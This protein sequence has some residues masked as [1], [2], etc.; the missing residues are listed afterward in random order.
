MENPE[1]SGRGRKSSQHSSLTAA[2]RRNSYVVKQKREIVSVSIL[3]LR[4]KF[5][6]SSGQA[7]TPTRGSQKD[8][9]SILADQ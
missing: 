1:R 4:G 2:S 7:N 9:S 8:M 3:P 6:I 5:K